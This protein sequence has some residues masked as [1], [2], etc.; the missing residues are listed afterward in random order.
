MGLGQHRDAESVMLEALKIVKELRGAEHPEYAYVLATLTDNYRLENRLQEAERLLTEAKANLEASPMKDARSVA[1]I[2][3]SLAYVYYKQGR[4]R[5]AKSL[6]EKV[7]EIALSTSTV[8]DQVNIRLLLAAV[9]YNEGDWRNAFDLLDNAAAFVGNLEVYEKSE[10]ESLLAG[11]FK[12][13]T[14]RVPSLFE[15]LAKVRF[16]LA[17]AN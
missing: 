7:K 8:V 9:A 1:I 3:N 6:L 11:D 2:R 12:L 16:R 15:A 10:Q 5:E 4:F 13:A 17:H 14:E